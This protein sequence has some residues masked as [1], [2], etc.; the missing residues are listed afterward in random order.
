MTWRFEA[1]HLSATSAQQQAVVVTVND[2][3]QLMYRIGDQM[4]WHLVTDLDVSDRLGRT[5]RFLTLPDGTKLETDDN[6]TVDRF[7][8]Q[9]TPTANRAAWL[10]RL[11][12]AVGKIAILLVVVILSAGAT[13]RYGIPV[14]AR[15]V[16]PLIPEQVRVLSSR[17]TLAT[18]DR[19][20][21]EP[22]Q[23]SQ[24]I[25]AAHRQLFNDHVQPYFDIAMQI[26]FRN[27]EEIGPNA[28]ALPDGTLVFTDQL[29]ALVSQDEYLAIAAHEAGHVVG[30][31]A[32]R[33]IISSTSLLV[34]IVLVTGD[35]EAISELLITAPTL[36][37]QL[38]YSRDLETEA[39]DV[40]YNW[41]QQTN[42]PL[43]TFA[44]AL[45]KIVHEHAA[46]DD[47]AKW[48]GYLSTH[49][50]PEQRIERFRATP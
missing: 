7:L 20:T 43:E 34:A 19:L 35:S 39:D 46:E 9:L 37:M 4:H 36:L 10:H 38:S 48:L 33:S 47:D 30:D 40:A 5:P 8:N 31:H 22:S 28:F 50:M 16:S 6:D 29:M 32:M 3:G 2:A 49:P 41:L 15:L 45:E 26:E 23:L 17:Q 18:F 14:F 11:E 13:Y 1:K 42:R 27:S 44:T 25:Q 12:G 24:E 21:L